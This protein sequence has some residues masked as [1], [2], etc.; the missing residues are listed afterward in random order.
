M[1]L[2]RILNLVEHLPPDSALLR[3]IASDGRPAEAWSNTDVLIARLIETEYLVYRQ[4][5]AM[6]RPKSTPPKPLRIPTGPRRRRRVSTSA[7][8]EFRSFFGAAVRYKPTAAE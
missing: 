8:P 4:L 5:A 1:E 2:R 3:T 7:D 6:A